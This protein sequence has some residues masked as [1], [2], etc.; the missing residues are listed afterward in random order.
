M[1]TK[2]KGF[3]S[4]GVLLFVLI[5][6]SIAGNERIESNLDFVIIK[7][8]STKKHSA[9]IN[10]EEMVKHELAIP[11]T[12]PI[13]LNA[14]INTKVVNYLSGLDAKTEEWFV[15]DINTKKKQK[16]NLL[17]LQEI[18][19]TIVLRPMPNVYVKR[20]TITNG[21]AKN[22]YLGFEQKT[23]YSKTTFTFPKNYTIEV[24]IYT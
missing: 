7:S 10:F 16:V 18:T 20:Y 14:H 8:Q 2:N 4:L 22:K 15:I 23:S 24:V 19:K 5:F 1:A 13:T 17:E 6:L 3:L 12:D 11:N 21:L 9:A